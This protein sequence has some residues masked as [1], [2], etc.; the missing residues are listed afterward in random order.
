MVYVMTVIIKWWEGGLNKGISKTWYC[1][2][3]SNRILLCC[4]SG[5]ST[6]HNHWS[7]HRWIKF[8]RVCNKET[9][10]EILTQCLYILYWCVFNIYDFLSMI[11]CSISFCG[12]KSSFFTVTSF[13]DHMHTDIDNTSDRVTGRGWGSFFP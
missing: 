2:K 10:P 4:H 11:S 3:N 9:I 6:R 7:V 13:S 8:Q 1:A 5:M 12:K